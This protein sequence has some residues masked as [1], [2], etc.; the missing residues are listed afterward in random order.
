MC[1]AEA[2]QDL[3]DDKDGDQR[4]QEAHVGGLKEAEEA[5]EQGGLA[6]KEGKCG[7][8]HLLGL[9]AAYMRRPLRIHDRK[10]P[11]MGKGR[12]CPGIRRGP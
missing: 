8:G 12:G 5:P 7:H 11:R 4:V 2:A 3:Q 1:M 9:A 10:A 6:A